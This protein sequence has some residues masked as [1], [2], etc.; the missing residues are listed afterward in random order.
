MSPVA[1]RIYRALLRLYPRELRDDVGEEMERLFGERYRDVRSLNRRLGIARLWLR[2]L[3]D[4]GWNVPAA[5]LGGFSM[6]ALLHDLRTA[7]RSLLRRPAFLVVATLT[8]ALG[9]GANAAIFG[10]VNRTLLEPLPYPS[11]DRL[12][13][14]WGKTATSPQLSAS[15]PELRDWRAGVHGIDRFAAWRGQSVNLTGDGEPER[16]SGAFVTGEFFPLLGAELILGRA[17]T[18][19]EGEPGTAAP[20]AVLSERLWQRRFGGA[21]DI[22]GRTLILNGRPRMVVGIARVGDGGPTAPYF[23][24]SDVWLPLADFPNAHGLDRG[25]GELFVLGH[26][27][28]GVGITAAEH[29]VAALEN[30]LASLYPDTQGGRTAWLQP[31]AELIVG[32]VRAPLLVLFAAVGIVLLISCVNV[33]NLLIARATQREKELALRAALGAGRWRL[34]RQLLT[35][36]VLLGALGGGAGLLLSVGLLRLFSAIAPAELGFLPE[37]GIDHKVFAYGLAVSLVCGLAFGL[38]PAFRASRPDVTGVLKG[39]GAAGSRGRRF[40]DGLVVLEGALSVL[41]LVG[42]G[43]L[44]RSADARAHSDP[45]FRSD[46]VLSAELRLPPAKYAAPAQIAAFFHSLVERL[47]ATPGIES[48]ALVRATPFENEGGDPFTVEGEPVPPAGHEAYAQTNVITPG[49]FRTLDIPLLVGRD[50]SHDDTG[51]R[52]RVIV[53]NR[54]LAERVLGG[55]A[56]GKRL[57]I[58]D[59]DGP[60]TIV[61]VVGDI[62]QRALDEAPQPQIYLCREQFPTIFTGIVVRTAGD[63]ASLVPALRAAVWAVDKDQPVWRLRTMADLLEADRRPMRALGFLVTLFAAVAVALAGVGLYGVMATVTAQR[64]REIGIRLALGAPTGRVLRD[65]VGRGLA[66]AAVAIV[67]GIAGALAL[68]RLV[69]GTLYGVSPADP[70]ALVVAPAIVVA[71]SVIASWFPAR[72]AARTDPARV[73]ASE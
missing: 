31:L 66:L 54:F 23:D 17:F 43:L 9:I 11:A 14:V 2:T 3:A 44:L 7:C 26:L 47:E 67:I 6:D 64:T 40:R 8:L 24:L 22:V 13:V 32:P 46:H 35:E 29:E 52:P 56:L 53:V 37:G 60:L 57:L 65:L 71:I 70:V 27:A 21:T 10:A 50:F 63:P 12:I 55:A 20:V 41:L 28:P 25:Q 49:F 58:K 18:V 33:A 51:D 42:A 48:A 62:R 59:Y 73:L 30:R 36:S 19:A 4:F 69:A 38:W 34:V 5:H 16:V 15:Y 45:G 72:R 68:G 61:G 1:R 39:Q